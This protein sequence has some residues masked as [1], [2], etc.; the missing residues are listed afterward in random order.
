MMTR[1][2]FM[3]AL[4]MVTTAGGLGLGI[5]GVFAQR[6]R[7][8]MAEIAPSTLEP[9]QDCPVA[10]CRA[11]GRPMR[12]VVKNVSS[13]RHPAR[14]GAPGTEQISLLL[15]V[16]ESD[17]PAGIYRVESDQVSLGDLYLSPVGQ[18]GRDQRLEAIITRIV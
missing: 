6:R 12:A 17:A 15:A 5:G 3:G 4:A 11:D 8:S 14:F 13:V 10:I 16:D 2:T 18:A 7:L 9:L 1:R